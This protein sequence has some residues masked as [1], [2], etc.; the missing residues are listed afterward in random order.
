MSNKI[1]Y[2]I[3]NSSDFWNVPLITVYNMHKP[4]SGFLTVILVNIERT[5][6]KIQKNSNY[7]SNKTC[8]I[9]LINTKYSP[10]YFVAASNS[11]CQVNFSFLCSMDSLKTTLSNIQIINARPPLYDR[12]E[13]NC[14]N[15]NNTTFTSFL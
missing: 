3:N 4:Q 2:N 15:I 5:V 7:L 6:I 13:K 1:R 9:Q 8:L 11:S 14:R 10:T 12:K